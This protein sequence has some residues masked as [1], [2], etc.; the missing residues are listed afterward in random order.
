MNK[1]GKIAVIAALALILI[2]TLIACNDDDY[3]YVFQT[4]A[5]GETVTDTNGEPVKETDGEGNPVTKP[6]CE[7]ESE[8]TGDG[9]FAAGADSDTGWG[10]LITPQS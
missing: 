8:N 5:N 3:E 1:I 9:I 7:T 4:D 10:E 2:M 6:A